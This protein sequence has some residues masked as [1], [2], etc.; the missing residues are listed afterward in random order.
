MMKPP[1]KQS[2][3][4]QWETS[5]CS[6]GLTTRTSVLLRL[7]RLPRAKDVSSIVCQMRGRSS[8]AER[9]RF[10]LSAYCISLT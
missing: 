2:V 8:I 5:W 4:S 10:I 1:V 6:G 9:K 3:T 7:K